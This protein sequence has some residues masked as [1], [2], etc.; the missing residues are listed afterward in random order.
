MFMVEERCLLGCFHGDVDYR[1]LLDFVPFD[2]SFNRRFGEHIAST[3]R[4]INSGSCG[5]RREQSWLRHYATI[6]KVADSKLEKVSEFLHVFNLLTALGPGI[7]SISN[8]NEY[9]RQK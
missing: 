6:R 4:L 3:E 2:Y 7:Y 5:G 9:H 8:R 1:C